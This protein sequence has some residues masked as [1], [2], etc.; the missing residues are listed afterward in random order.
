MFNF[1]TNLSLNVSNEFSNT[2]EQTF[3]SRVE[4]LN[5]KYKTDSNENATLINFLEIINE[6]NFKNFDANLKSGY[7]KIVLKI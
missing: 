1:E 3:N 2:N 6:F 4:K 5:P 7:G